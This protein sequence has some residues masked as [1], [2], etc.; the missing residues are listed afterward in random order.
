MMPKLRGL[1]KPGTV[2]GPGFRVVT[3][4]DIK[5]HPGLSFE[6]YQAL[7]GF[8]YSTLKKNGVPF[9]GPTAK[10]GLGTAV[11]NYLLEPHLF[12]HSNTRAKKLA[13][14]LKKII[15]TLLPFMEFEMSVTG[16]MEHQGFVMP[17]RG[18]IDALI[19]KKIVVDL[20]ATEID[21]RKGID[22]FGYQHPMTGYM[23]GAQTT[24]GYIIGINTKTQ[25]TQ[26]V[27]II[28]THAFWDKK[29]MEFGWPK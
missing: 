22:F 6:Q 16:S 19:R 25:V 14:E 27:P 2:N 28:P 12:D 13:I 5:Y 11:H 7:P 29:I 23:A 1:N 8:S 20:K 24:T 4:T 18:R 21:V 3:I 15:G 10:M 17:W 26:T 9:A